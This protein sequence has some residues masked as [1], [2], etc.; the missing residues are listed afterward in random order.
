MIIKVIYKSKHQLQGCS[1]DAAAGMNFII[2]VN[3]SKEN[4]VLKDGERI[5]QKFIAKH[6]NAEWQCVELL[7][8]SERGAGGL[9]YS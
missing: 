1:T 9:V 4:P 3:L 8:D 7:L 2:L 5:C 6:E